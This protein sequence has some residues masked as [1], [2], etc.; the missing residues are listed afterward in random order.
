MGTVPGHF[1]ASNDEKIDIHC[2]RPNIQFTDDYL[3]TGESYYGFVDNQV[4]AL[5]LVEATI[6][7]TIP[8]FSGSAID[9]ARLRIRSGTVL[10]ISESCRLVKR[11]K[12]GL[13]WSP[14]RAYGSF[15]LYRQTCNVSQAKANAT[16]SRKRIRVPGATPFFAKNVLK[17]GTDILKEGE[18]YL[19]E[20]FGRDLKT[21]KLDGLT[22]RSIT[23]KGSDGKRH[24]V[25]SYY[26][27][28]DAARISRC[29]SNQSS[30]AVD[31][32]GPPF[33]R[34]SLDTR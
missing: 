6:A 14:S 33:M 25:I 8:A 12:D 28:S 15:L 32:H 27:P 23:I 34:P 19:R 26:T 22:K 30:S 24:R 31:G 18:D 17:P 16:S 9:V 10:V 11:W 1:T 7:G 29:C 5:L 2:E 4:D 3:E 13:Q 20:K 21:F